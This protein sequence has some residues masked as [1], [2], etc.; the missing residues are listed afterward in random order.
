MNLLPDLRPS[1][2][3]HPKNS[4]VMFQIKKDFE[5]RTKI[6]RTFFGIR[7]E[8]EVFAENQVE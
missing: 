7:P 3:D 6:I 5:I 2:S 1:N 4:L 8:P